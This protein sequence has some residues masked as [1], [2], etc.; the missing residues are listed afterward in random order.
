MKYQLKRFLL[1]FNTGQGRAALALGLTL[2]ALLVG[3]ADDSAG[4]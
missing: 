4:P 2:V 1:F 3:G